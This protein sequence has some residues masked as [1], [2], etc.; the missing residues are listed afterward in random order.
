MATKLNQ[1]IQVEDP[2]NGGALVTMVVN[3]VDTIT[4][5][6][7]AASFLDSANFKGGNA[8]IVHIDGVDGTSVNPTTFTGNSDI[9]INSITNEPK[10]I[11]KLSVPFSTINN[12]SLGEV[13]NLQ[14]DDLSTDLRITG[15]DTGPDPLFTS[16]T[17]A[18]AV[19][20]G[21][22]PTTPLDVNPVDLRKFAGKSR[23]TVLEN[24]TGA[25]QTVTINRIDPSTNQ[26]FVDTAGRTPDLTGYDVITAVFN[27][28]LTLEGRPVSLG[29]S[30][31][32]IQ[33]VGEKIQGLLEGFTQLSTGIL[34]GRRGT[35]G[36][37]LLE[38]Q[39]DL[40]KFDQRLEDRE[41]ELIREFATLEI[42]LGQ[43]QIQSQFL[44]AQL[45]A[46]QNVL[47]GFRGRRNNNR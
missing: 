30:E 34:D 35:I 1:T 15:I 7:R 43:I 9:L 13:L 26:V 14:Q 36:S 29:A 32:A 3:E 25:S 2:T 5:S 10:N 41:G 39:A 24:T 28:V 45:A 11:S 8:R 42:A 37:Q 16:V 22:D 18:P 38:V 47:T 27:D 46:L 40:Q 19:A 12:F 4:R 17:L 21:S 20:A 6:V 33:G 44:T 23:L 31:I